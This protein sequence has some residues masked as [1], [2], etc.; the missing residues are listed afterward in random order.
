M[1]VQR[2]KPGAQIPMRAHPTDAGF[3]VTAIDVLK[4][5]GDVTFYG[6][7]IRVCPPDG[8][9]FDLVPRSS[10]SKTGYILANSVGIIDPGYTGEIIVALRKIDQGAKDLELPMRIAQ[11]IPRRVHSEVEMTECIG[12]LQKTDRGTGGFGSTSL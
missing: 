6:T 1:S 4:T 7:G 2:F 12:D 3:D 8:F 9:Y 11:L 10:V 5:Q